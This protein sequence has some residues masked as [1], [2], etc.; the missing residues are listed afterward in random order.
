M[1]FFSGLF[2]KASAMSLDEAFK[3]FG[4]YLA[5]N[6]ETIIIAYEFIRDIII[7]TDKRLIVIDV[8]GLSGKRKIIRS[9]KYESITSFS[10]ETD[11]LLTSSVKLTIRIDGE[12]MRFKLSSN[13]D[14]AKLSKELT[15]RLF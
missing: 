8:K 11:S 2:G 9:I 5:G 12:S 4:D 13:T 6:E 7:F 1:S 14:C 3:E 10:I 15:K